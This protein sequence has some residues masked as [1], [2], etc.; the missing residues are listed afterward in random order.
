M[1]N[2]FKVNL[3]FNREVIHKIIQDALDKEIVGYV[4]SV[5]GN[6]L[7]TANKNPAHLE[8][9]NGAIVNL[10]DS[11]W[12]PLFVNLIYKTDY[13]NSTGADFFLKTIKLKR[14]RQFFLGSTTEI[15][16]GLR[17]RMSKIDPAIAEMRFETL[18]F[19]NVDE[20]DYP[21]IAQMI[22]EDN[23]DIIWVSLGA[24]KQE[25]FMSHLK[26]FLKKGLMFGFGA[27]FNF[28]SGY[29]SQK[30]A[31]LWVIRLKLEWFFRTIQEPERMGKRYW[32]VF[33]SFPKLFFAELKV[34]KKKK[35]TNN[36]LPT[37]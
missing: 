33:I 24:P 18:P 26:P 14:Y 5:D 30:R 11:A 19:R 7:I 16:A 15:L 9:L 28:N 27:I 25:Q 13:I 22:R 12:I 3:E 23:P 36:K 34:S 20:F 37:V 2:Y 4:C 8:A 32:N 29:A 1:D 31:P 6:S 21:A 35:K 10:C 17:S